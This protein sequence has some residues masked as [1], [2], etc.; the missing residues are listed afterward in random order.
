MTQASCS[1][2]GYKYTFELGNREQTMMKFVPE[3]SDGN[4]MDVNE[5]HK[6]EDDE[7]GSL[8]DPIVSQTIGRKKDKRR[9]KPI[10]KTSTTKSLHKCALCKTYTNYDAR[11]H[12]KTRSQH[13]AL[14]AIKDAGVPL[15]DYISTLMPKCDSEYADFMAAYLG[16]K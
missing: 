6:E 9:K 3:E 12:Y 13:E 10:E 7:I 8:L 1:M 16:R 5:Q 4:V 11:N 2:E 15:S 14:V